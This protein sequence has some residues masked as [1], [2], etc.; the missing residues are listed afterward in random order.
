VDLKDRPGGKTVVIDFDGR[1]V[2]YD[3][4]DLD[5]II[6]AYAVSVHKSQGANTRS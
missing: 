3:Y 5:E 6:L 2:P 1:P 4:S